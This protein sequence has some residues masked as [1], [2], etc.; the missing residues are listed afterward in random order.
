MIEQY[1]NEDDEGCYY[2]NPIRC[3]FDDPTL[4]FEEMCYLCGAFGDQ[5]ELVACCLCAESFHTYCL[6]LSSNEIE[7]MFQSNWKCIN[8][9]ACERC[10][11]AD[12]EDQLNFCGT[13]DRP[14][15]S[16]CLDPEIKH[17]PEQWKCEI[18]FKC[19]SCSTTKFYDDKAVAQG[20][21]FTNSDYSLSKNFSLCFNCGKDRKLME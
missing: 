2:S 5:H 21:N 13:C 19:T 12:N 1:Q 10:G 9:K 11:K 3:S 20:Y 17:I 8:C 18:C 16:Y 4:I 7:S 14:F 15:H 6:Q